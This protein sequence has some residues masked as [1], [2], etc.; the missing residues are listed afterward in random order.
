MQVVTTTNYHGTL[1]PHTPTAYT[2][3]CLSCHQIVLSGHGAVN[4]DDVDHVCADTTSQMREWE[5]SW[6]TH[7]GVDV[8]P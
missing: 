5:I 7:H 1:S 8:D 3:R 4:T 2:V 6:A